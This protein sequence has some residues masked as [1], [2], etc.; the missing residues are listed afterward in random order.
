M[1]RAAAVARACP[2]RVPTADRRASA[3]RPTPAPNVH[4]RPRR[5]GSSIPFRASAEVAASSATSEEESPEAD[6]MPS[7]APGDDRPSPQGYYRWPALHGDVLVFVCEDDLWR[8]DVRGGVA[9][10]ITDAPGPVLA[11]LVSRDGTRVAF[12]VQQDACQ[13]IYA[14]STRGGPVTQVTHAGAERTRAACWSADGTRLFFASSAGQSFV[15]TEELWCVDV[16]GGDDDGDGTSRRERIVEPRR[17]AFGPVHDAC[18]RPS[19][20]DSSGGDSIGIGAPLLVARNSQDT[21]AAHWKGYRGGCGGSLWLD[22]RGDGRRFVRLDVRLEG[23]AI[24]GGRNG[25]NGRDGGVN[26]GSVAWA[27]DDRI[28]LVGDDGGGRSNL[29][30]FDAADAVARASVVAGGDAPPDGVG[31]DAP[32]VSVVATRHTAR[33][34]HCVRHASP[35]AAAAPNAKSVNVAYVSG[36]RLFTSVLGGE[37]TGWGPVVGTEV[38]VEWSGSRAGRERRA[39]DAEDYVDGWSI[40]PEGLTMLANVRGRMFSMGLW[41]GPA[42]EYAPVSEQDPNVE[43]AGS[44]PPELAPPGAAQLRDLVTTHGAQPRCRLGRYLWDGRRVAMVTDASGEDD[45][46]IHSEDGDFRKRRL[47]VPPAVLG[48]VDEMVPSP[49]SPLIAVVNHRSR[50]LIVDAETGKVRTADFSDE[51]GGVGDLA[52]WPCGNFSTRYDDPERSRVRILDARRR[53]SRRDGAGA[54]RL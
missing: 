22:P 30:S 14:V 50:L 7:R 23:A 3:S 48:R 49:E 20:G 9:A 24:D 11:P 35:D 40:H 37:D 10:R 18:V 16:A 21:A 51:S 38:R 54:R 39:V 6:A 53:G 25:R 32:V 31:G 46:E 27:V 13:E 12:T 41:D 8:C 19:V 34:D 1:Q 26:I 42:L 5:S 2:L 28:T 17:C 47:C 4:R 29:Y 15:D 33:S 36:G 43:V 44:I 45:V 52:G